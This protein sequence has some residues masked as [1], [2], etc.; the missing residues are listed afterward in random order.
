M[1]SWRRARGRHGGCEPAREAVGGGGASRRAVSV[2][3]AS[4]GCAAAPEAPD[5]GEGGG[6]GRRGGRR[7]R[8]GSGGREGGS[9]TPE[10]APELRGLEWSEVC[11]W[12][13]LTNHV[14]KVAETGGLMTEG[15][16]WAQLCCEKSRRHSERPNV[17]FACPD[18]PCRKSSREWRP[19]DRGTSLGPILM[20]K[21]PK[22]LQKAE[23]S[24]RVRKGIQRQTSSLNLSEPKDT[25]LDSRT[26]R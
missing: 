5:G 15:P 22:T 18:R 3:W 16:P 4:P 19:E 8:E 17:F 2:S 24:S 12:H 21:G 7:L 20:Q 9:P 13:S 25:V 6:R 11:F 1:R 26:M 10:E 23:V 14:G